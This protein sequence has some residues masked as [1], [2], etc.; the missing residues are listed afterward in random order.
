MIWLQVTHDVTLSNITPLNNLL[1]NIYF[2]NSTAG[3]HV[4]YIY[5]YILNMRANFHTNKILFSI[6]SISS[7]FIYYF[8]L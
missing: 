3:L 2:K 5:I 1:M 4:L 6:R 8:K 7:S